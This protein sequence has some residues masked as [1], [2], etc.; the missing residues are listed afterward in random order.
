MMKNENPWKNYS[1]LIGRSPGMFFFF[2]FFVAYM[3]LFQPG[4]GVS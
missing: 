1:V 4:A 2:I 3:L